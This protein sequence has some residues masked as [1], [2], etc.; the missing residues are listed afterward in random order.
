MPLS[1]V[2]SALTGV[3]PAL[4]PA[5]LVLGLSIASADPVF[6]LSL[7]ASTGANEGTVEVRTP[8]PRRT[9]NRYASGRVQPAKTV[10][11]LPAVVYL[12][13]GTV[14]RAPASPALT[15]AQQ[16]TSFAP[17][18]LA[19]QV[20]GMVEFPNGDPFFH[21]VFSYSQVQ[22]FDLGRYPLG[23]SK[24]VTFGEPGVVKIYCEVH[25]FMRAAVLVL[26][27]AHHAVVSD[28]GS[29]VIAGVPPGDYQLVTWHADL[30]EQATPITV[31]AGETQNVD[32]TLR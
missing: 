3:R 4:T 25:D 26:E 20:G 5:L 2:R 31:R 21:N 13:G 9:A 24:T 32:V 15:M 30:D 14:D 18:V 12:I 27:S 8:P 23:E 10:Q 6:A 22:R 7:Q 1:R 17:P 19:V 28:D 16:D 11:Q 29:F